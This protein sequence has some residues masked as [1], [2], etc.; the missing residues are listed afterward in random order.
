[1]NTKHIVI[2]MLLYIFMGCKKDEAT[3]TKATNLKEYLIENCSHVHEINGFYIVASNEIPKEANGATSK[4]IWEHAI[5]L[6]SNYLDQNEDGIID[7]DKNDLSDALTKH[8][9]FCIGSQDFVDKISMGKFVVDKLT[10]IGMHTDS[11]PYLATYTGKGWKFDKLDSSTWRP[12]AFNA[13][14][15]ETYHTLTEALSRSDKSFQFTKGKLLRETMDADIKAKTYETEVQ[16]R[17]E[18]GNYDTITAVNEYIHQIWAITNA[19]YEV[20]L[21]D[22]QKKALEFMKN[23]GIILSVDPNYP[24]MIGTTLK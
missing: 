4:E 18:N 8:M 14:W 16:N 1:M 5:K 3:P 17:E 20:K 6:F 24:Y 9:L 12:E 13:L 11:W 10:T 15:E 7:S 21:N 22:L 2:V 23:K 19:G